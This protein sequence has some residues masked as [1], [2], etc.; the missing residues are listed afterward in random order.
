MPECHK[1]MVEGD[2]CLEW[3]HMGYIELDEE[4]EGKIMA[5]QSL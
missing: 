5:L 1:N 2:L 4:P 3:F